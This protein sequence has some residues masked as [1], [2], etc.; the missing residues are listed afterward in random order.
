MIQEVAGARKESEAGDGGV[1]VEEGSSEDI[2][3]EQRPGGVRK[4][5]SIICGERVYSKW[6]E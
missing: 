6:R 1:G 3:M 2:D 5:L 4:G